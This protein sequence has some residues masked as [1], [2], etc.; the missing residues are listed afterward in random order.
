MS[1]QDKF[2][3]PLPELV[4]SVTVREVL[5]RGPS[6]LCHSKERFAEE[7]VQLPAGA[8][9][10]FQ[11]ALSLLNKRSKPQ[12]IDLGVS[13]VCNFG[14]RAEGLRD[15]GTGWVGRDVFGTMTS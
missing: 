3:S 6:S 10:S 9:D 2:V 15:E 11:D 13:Q 14:G 12:S 7:K 8:L 5:L 4:S 1:A